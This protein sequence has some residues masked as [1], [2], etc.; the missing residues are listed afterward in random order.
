MRK[1]SKCQ[2]EWCFRER[3]TAS[4]DWLVLSQQVTGTGG[5]SSSWSPFFGWGHPYPETTGYI[6]PTLLRGADYLGDDRYQAIAW[7][8]TEW[9]LSL[10]HDEGWFPGGTLKPNCEHR[11]SIFN[12]GQILFGLAASYT[13][14]ND[15]RVRVA[16]ERGVKWLCGQQ[17]V[18]GRW[19]NHAYVEGYSPSY[20][21]HVC[22]PIAVLAKALGN[23]ELL[24]YVRRGIEAV[25]EDRRKN[26][27]YSRWAFNSGKPAFT[28]TMAY[29]LQGVVESAI[30]T[31]EWESL[32]KPAVDTAERLLRKFEI[33]RKLAGSYDQTWRGKY[34]Y[35]CL[36]GHC[37]I[38]STWMRI[39]EQNGD[40]RFLDAA[41]KLMEVVRKK[42]KLKGRAA[43]LGAIG[44]SSP[45][46]GSYM[47][48]RYPNWAA[49]FFVDA[50]ME[51]EGNLAALEHGPLNDA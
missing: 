40:V 50:M 26:G 41:A 17:E 47:R 39:Y 22:W 51:L 29:T 12:T 6:V 48:L 44:G 20:Y 36:T 13:H 4:L 21:A 18:D 37:Q 8:M 38:A 16:A 27:T 5:S 10:Q 19:L 32:A 33:R 2:N 42:Q 14:E 31:D 43:R 30:I 23:E 45:L 35:I 28:H 3:I 25:N 9:L 46:W 49:K 1:K 24:G 11:P 15:T 34:W 7:E